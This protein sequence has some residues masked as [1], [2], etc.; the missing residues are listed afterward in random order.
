MAV[1]GPAHADITPNKA[2]KGSS[3][4][5][6][7]GST[8]LTSCIRNALTGRHRVHLAPTQV[9]YTNFRHIVIVQYIP[10]AQLVSFQPISSHLQVVTPSRRSGDVHF[11]DHHAQRT[12]SW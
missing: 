5:C 3:T 6:L 8:G 10:G 12:N 1:S 11:Q 9:T 4:D 7:Q 2:A